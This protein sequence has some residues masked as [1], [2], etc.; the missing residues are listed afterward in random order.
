MNLPPIDPREAACRDLDLDLWFAT[1]DVGD[2]DYTEEQQIAVEICRRCPVIDPCRQWALDNISAAY[3][4]TFGGL[5][6]ADRRHVRRG[7]PPRRMFREMPASAKLRANFLIRKR[8]Q[9]EE[10]DAAAV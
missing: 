10:E 9:Q 8:D 1:G 2:H 4:G 3:G 6:D 7:T 5:T